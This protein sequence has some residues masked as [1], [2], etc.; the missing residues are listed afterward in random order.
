[1]ESSPARPILLALLERPIAAVEVEAPRRA[2]RG[3]TL[4]IVVR[5][6]PGSD[7]AVRMTVKAPDG[8]TFLRRTLLLDDGV[9]SFAM[10]VPHNAPAGP[11]VIEARDTISHRTART[12]VL[13]P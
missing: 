3:G 13:V 10:P 4:R 1:V 5:V 7:G 8:R 11:W 6:L 12:A 2:T 9:A